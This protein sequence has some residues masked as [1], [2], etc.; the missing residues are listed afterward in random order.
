MKRVLWMCNM[1]VSIAMGKEASGGWVTSLANLMADEKDIILG[2]CFPYVGHKER[3]YLNKNNIEY[4]GFCKKKQLPTIYD[5]D[6]ET[7]IR[8]ILVAFQPDIVQIFGTEFPHTLAMVKAFAN[9]SR[10]VI[11]IQGLVS[12]YAKHYQQGIPYRVCCAFSFR[13]F[14][15]RDNIF[16][17]AVKFS[18]RGK[19]EIE[20]LKQVKY[21]MGR[22]EWDKACLKQI[23]NKLTYI[24]CEE[25]LR[26]EFYSGKW[27]LHECERYSIFMSQASYPIKGLHIMLDALRIILKFY[28]NVCLYIAGENIIK[29]R[30]VLDCLR[31]TSYIKYLRKKIKKAGLEKHI[32]FLGPL[33]SERMKE[34]YLKAHVFVSPSVIENSSN[35]ICEAMML[36]VPVVSSDVGGV[37]S[38]LQHGVEGFLYQVDAPYMLSY[39]VMEL[40]EKA[41]LSIRVG[42]AAYIRANK[43]HE[44]AVILKQIKNTYE[45]MLNGLDGGYNEGK[46]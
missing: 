33:D 22:T 25:L 17:Q 12:V 19:Y 14:I 42:D 35:S 11:H 18:I 32:K 31:R 1:G 21:V 39:H 24:H 13:D 41:E 44:A 15:K 4:H 37:Q 30:G 43:R 23:N 29:K 5:E 36:G 34:Q 46:L 6:C 20:A 26:P 2:I 16:E 8:E 45:M 9:P 28:P 7:S 38:L 3:F 40:F 10:T 27:E